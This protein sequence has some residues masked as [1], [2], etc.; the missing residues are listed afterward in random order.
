M[1]VHGRFKD[2]DPLQIPMDYSLVHA[3]PF[4]QMSWKSDNFTLNYFS[5]NIDKQSQKH[6]IG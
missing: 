2:L 4:Q 3:A 5:N 6:P 1:Y